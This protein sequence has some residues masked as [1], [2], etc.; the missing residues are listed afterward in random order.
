MDID[1]FVA[2]HSAEWNRLELLV[3]RA[4][5]PARLAGGDV[6]ELVE[7][8]QRTATHLSV[9][10]SRFPDPALVARLSS[11]VARARAAVTGSASP[12]WR[13]VA[14]FFTVTFPAAAWRCRRWWAGASAGSL[15]VAVALA[16]WIA[17]HPQVQAQLAPPDVVRQLVEHDFAAY[18]TEHPAQA[19]AAMVWTNNAWVAAGS[20]SL[21]VFFGLPTLF[22]LLQNAV[23]VGIAAGYLTAAGKAGLFYGLVLPHGLL[24][25]TAV[26]LAAGAGLRLGW[27]VIDPGPRRRVDALAA[28]GRAAMT[29][30][31]GL[32]G[33]LLVSGVVEAFVTPSPLPTVARV[34]IGVLVEVAFVAYVVVL[35]RRASAAGRTGDLPA[36][37]AGDV[38]PSA[39]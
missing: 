26:F 19:F 9:V 22:I 17:S 32:V 30:A 13:Q 27:T 12:S 18:Y 37:L 16:A 36:E 15:A 33:V 20:L 28:E 2:A 14:T 24:E 6:D 21:G 23:N 35:G 34:S 7:L 25:L 5:R 3:R 29:I 4:G 31:I 11:L 1:A 8:Y 10:Q 39:G 38:A